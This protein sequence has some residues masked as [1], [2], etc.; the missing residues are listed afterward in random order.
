VAAVAVLT[1]VH[2][3]VA[4]VA[5]LVASLMNKRAVHL[6]D[7]LY[8]RAAPTKKGSAMTVCLQNFR[9]VLSHDCIMSVLLS[10][11]SSMCFLVLFDTQCVLCIVICE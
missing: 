7:G 11:R 2:F 8:H 6:S 9:C 1:R 10:S 3:E 4:A 5:V